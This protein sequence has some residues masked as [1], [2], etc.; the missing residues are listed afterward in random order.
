MST[1][2]TRRADEGFTLVELTVALGLLMVVLLAS[3]PAFL[4]MLRT[5]VTTKVQTQ[6]KNLSQQRLEQL[7]DLRYHIDR[8]NGPFLDL[9]DIYYTNASTAGTTTTVSV[10]GVTQTGTYV[11]AAAASGAAPAGP[12]YRVT[13]S[14]VLTG[15]TFTQ[16]IYTQFL[17]PS[18]APISMTPFQDLYD[19]QTPGRDASP[20]GS[21]A[22]TIVTSWLDGAK[23]KTLT[24]KTRIVD[25]RPELAV[26]QTQARAT[27]VIVSSSGADGATLQLDAGVSNVDGSQSSTSAVS[28]LA[29]G[30]LASRTGSANVSGKAVSFDLPTTAAS[31]VNNPSPQ[32]GGSGCSWFGFGASGVDNGSGSVSTGLPKAPANVD[33]TTPPTQM[34][35]Y[36]SANGG[37]SCGL[38]SYDNLAGGGVPR[39]DAIST[40]MGSAPYVK[41][42]DTT[43]SGAVVLGSAYATSSI[44]TA[45]PQKSESGATARSTQPVVLFPNS[46]VPD[47]KGL[48]TLRLVQL[49]AHL[50]IVNDRRRPR[51]SDGRLHLRARLVGTGPERGDPE[52]AH[53]D[54]GLQLRDFRTGPAGRERDLEPGAD[55]PGQRDQAERP[56]HL[57][58]PRRG[59]ECAQHGRHYGPARIQRRHLQRHDRQHLEQRATARLLRD[60][61]DRGT[62][63]L[64]GG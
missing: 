52:P 4:G 10:D 3:L 60:Q 8:Q 49:V 43:G 28:G 35:G 64:R 20:A 11:S 22:V 7:K 1:S 32:S 6:A 51:N 34:S 61:S 56:H 29:T 38:L 26:I 40:K 9:L 14:R 37:G 59:P 44:L 50:H 62:A 18:G 19:S 57:P 55:R 47:G 39:S 27:A 58:G 30:A 16:T 54:M 33:S 5:S 45:S 13:L 46:P 48:V 12:F 15:K 21:V 2:R 53:C 31:T 42:P 41:I 63:H 24:A 23:T 25:G 36:L 17:G